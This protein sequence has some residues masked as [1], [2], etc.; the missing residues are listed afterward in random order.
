MIIEFEYFHFNGYA[1]YFFITLI[2]K[3]NLI[4]EQENK[5]QQNLNVV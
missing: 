3:K 4:D 2:K 1:C 5:L